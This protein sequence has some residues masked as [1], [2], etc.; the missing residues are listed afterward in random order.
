[1]NQALMTAKDGEEGQPRV[2][3]HETASE[4]KVELYNCELN[5]YIRLNLCL[6][7]ITS[8]TTSICYFKKIKKFSVKY[9]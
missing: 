9:K 1:M 6:K 3:G 7:T 2:E 4:R 8:F 5:M